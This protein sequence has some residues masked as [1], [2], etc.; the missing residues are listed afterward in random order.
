MSVSG[1][2]FGGE[3]VIIIISEVQ[4][5]V[6]SLTE[7]G[8]CCE[9]VR[10]STL[11][12]KKGCAVRNEFVLDN[13]FLHDQYFGISETCNRRRHEHVRDCNRASGT[14]RGHT[15]SGKTVEQGKHN[16]SI[17]KAENDPA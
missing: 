5:L 8:L 2:I 11:S 13:A 17:T 14:G 7:K 9:K 10:F 3:K 16:D 15:E 4:V 6:D 1:H 12:P